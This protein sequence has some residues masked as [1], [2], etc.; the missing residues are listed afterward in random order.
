MGLRQTNT[1][2][3]GNDYKPELLFFSYL[4]N[5]KRIKLRYKDFFKK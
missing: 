2:T 4:Q 1:N 3:R 5:Y